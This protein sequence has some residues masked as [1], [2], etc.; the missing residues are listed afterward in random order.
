MHHNVHVCKTYP[1]L[2]VLLTCE[3][4]INKQDGRCKG[5]RFV[6]T[7]ASDLHCTLSEN[8]GNKSFPSTIPFSGTIPMF[9]PA[10][11]SLSDF[12]LNL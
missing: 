3:S 4:L 6:H 8:V 12:S 10:N 7:L 5:N 2:E 9:K 11:N 1:I